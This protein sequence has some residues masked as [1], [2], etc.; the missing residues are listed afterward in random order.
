MDKLTSFFEKL[1]PYILK[2][3]NAK[4]TSAIK[5][6]FMLTMP[7]TLIG[8]IFLLI[9]NV[10]IP[11]YT[12][13]M[14]NMFGTGW[15]APLYQ[16]V[17]A[18]F[19]IVALV[20]VF[21]IAYAY[22]KNEGID[23]V[24]AGILGIVA[25]II[26]SSSSVTAGG[27]TVGGVI[28]KAYMGGKGMIA[29]IIIG[30]AVGY[31]YSW[32]IKRDIRIKMPEGV[33]QGVAN[34]F[35]AL[36]PATFI[37]VLAF[38]V[39]L[40]FDKM[41]DTTLVVKIYDILQTPIQNMTDSIG[42]VILIPLLMGLCWWC[43]IHGVT[44]IMGIMG[45][46]LTANSLANQAIVDSGQVLVAGENAKILTIQLIDQ[47]VTFGGA[48]VTIGLVIAM[49]WAAK[50]AQFKQLSK[51]SIVPGIFNINE[52]ILFGMPIVFNPIMLVPF[53]VVPVA[54]A[55]ITYFA[56]AFGII[57][58]FAGILV[59]WTTPPIISGFLIGGW[60]AAL[61][62]IAMIAM[63]ACVYYPFMKIADKQAFEEEEKAKESEEE[64]EFDFQLDF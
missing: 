5:D 57:D 42:G 41:Y 39:Y 35:T 61:L 13:M 9:A 10:P 36:I 25:M 11:G 48:G 1:M 14:A 8:S 18:T 37:M 3:A 15:D 54:S 44:L 7:L 47:F 17:G 31:I 49:L 24:S 43:G 33:P 38:L 56:I 12:D 28:P 45:P 4:P 52:P 59:P 23:G 46:I 34:A 2:F 22:T 40:L 53:I 26:V 6:G 29:A 62:Q 32:F 19:D 27:E 21:G 30:L 20:G 60:K 58:P 50:S 55:L 64:E 51:L 16:V 63:S